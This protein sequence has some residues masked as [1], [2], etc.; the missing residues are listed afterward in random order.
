M[1]LNIRKNISSYI[2]VISLVVIALVFTQLTGGIFLYS[3]N[4]S[5]LA[6]Q[7]TIV[8]TLAIGMM[9]V[10]VAGH[11]D[12]SVGSVLGFCGVVAAVLQVWYGWDTFPTIVVTILVGM[13]CGVWH[14]YWVA[15]RKVP[16]FIITL[17]GLL[18]FRGA[19]LGLGNSM[20]IAPMNPSFSALGQSYVPATAGWI[21]AAVAVAG[22][23]FTTYQRRRSAIKYQAE[24]APV[25]MDVARAAA[26]SLA[27]VF[28]IGYLNRYQGIPM[29]VLIMLVLAVIFTFVAKRTVF[30]RNVYAI[31]GNIEASALSGIQTRITTLVV[32]ILSSGMAAVAGMILTARLDAATPAA[33]DTMELD[34]IAACVIGGTSMA[35]GVGKVPAVII[36]ALVMASL[37]N[38]MS[39]INLE[40]YWQFIVKGL[41]LTLAVWA[42]T[43]SKSMSE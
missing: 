42:D 8:G 5:L 1:R 2:M 15:Y 26:I 17:G 19:K 31:G 37:D 13:A 33:G 3:R 34:A 9:F 16:A 32:F 10:I 35:G 7:T 21:I 24:T 18:A 40:N 20:S 36:G 22:V 30:G 29:P 4:I 39:L 25:M 23:L 28:G 41:V 11:I 38:G 27:I 14:G 6:R 12:L 43:M